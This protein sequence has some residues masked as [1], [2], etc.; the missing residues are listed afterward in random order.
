MRIALLAAAIAAVVCSAVGAYAGEGTVAGRALLAQAGQPPAPQPQPQAQQP[1]QQQPPQQQA[2]P[3]HNDN[4]EASRPRPRAAAPPRRDPRL[5]TRECSW[6]GKR[7]IRVLMRD[8]LIAAE[9]FLKF[10]NTFGCPVRYLGQ[11][12]GCSLAVPE[13]TAARE[14][15]NRIDACWANPAAKP[16]TAAAPE[17]APGQ[18]QQ[19]K[20]GTPAARPAAP[21]PAP[22]AAKPAAPA[23]QPKAPDTAYPPKR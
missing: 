8:D 22:P 20:P 15:E 18:Q 2:E 19:Q 4:A 13:G 9:G 11:A 21:R 3:P 10:Y 6:V 12:F 1:Q 17:A 16:E 14:I 23:A 5:D 7:T